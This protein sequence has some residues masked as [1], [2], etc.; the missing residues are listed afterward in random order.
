M[1]ETESTAPYV[2][3]DDG[4]N[5]LP[6][7]SD[8]DDDDD[9]DQ[10]QE[11][12]ST[13]RKTVGSL[14]ERLVATIHDSDKDAA[15]TPT[16]LSIRQRQPQ[17]DEPRST[18]FEPLQDQGKPSQGKE[19]IPLATP[20]QS[21]SLPPTH[22]TSDGISGR[23]PSS[24]WLLPPTGNPS[25]EDT[26][27]SHED[28]LHQPWNEDDYLRHAIPWK[29]LEQKAYVDSLLERR[30]HY[31]TVKFIGGMT[32]ALLGLLVLLGVG[33]IWKFYP[34]HANMFQWDGSMSL[35]TAVQIAVVGG[36]CLA[37]LCWSWEGTAQEQLVNEE[38]QR[39]TKHRLSLVQPPPSLRPIP[40]PP[41][42]ASVVRFAD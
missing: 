20:C 17:N 1:S 19:E 33:A 38:I 16:P 2:C 34:N 36:F 35:Q 37:P 15:T 9:D 40:M 28:P 23:S 4:D 18:D 14:H 26:M 22:P 30:A 5:A 39:L 27:P 6:L 3:W 41:K 29:S 32:V 31:R 13:S 24:S 8:D 25:T 12:A 11:P 10:P 7:A 42:T 21:G